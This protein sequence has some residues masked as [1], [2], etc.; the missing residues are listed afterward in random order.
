MY[1]KL[2]PFHLFM[3]PLLKQYIKVNL[4]DFITFYIR[5][6]VWNNLKMSS[7][8]CFKKSLPFDKDFGLFSLNF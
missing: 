4:I 3:Y 5:Y 7:K 2:S 8:S 6:F 1:R